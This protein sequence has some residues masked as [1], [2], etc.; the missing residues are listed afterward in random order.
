MH[1]ANITTASLDDRVEPVDLVRHADEVKAVVQVPAEVPHDPQQQ[2]V[3]NAL[4]ETRKMLMQQQ[5]EASA[6][7]AQQMAALLA[8]CSGLQQIRAESAEQ[9][10]MGFAPCIALSMVR[11]ELLPQHKIMYD[12]FPLR[13]AISISVRQGNLE[14]NGEALRPSTAGDGFHQSVRH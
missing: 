11:S 4:L 5:I 10:S 2:E 6:G 13:Y 8:F 1:I 9:I 12:S 7:L 14:R 3:I